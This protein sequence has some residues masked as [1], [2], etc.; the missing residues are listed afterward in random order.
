MAQTSNPYGD[1]LAMHRA[2][3]EGYLDYKS[4]AWIDDNPYGP[5][6][7]LNKS[8]AWTQGWL[9]AHE[10]SKRTGDETN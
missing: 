9:A 6:D 4:G 3:K 10:D 5:L 7:R 2:W 1:N 8:Q